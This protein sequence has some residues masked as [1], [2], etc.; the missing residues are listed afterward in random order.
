MSNPSEKRYNG[1]LI[2]TPVVKDA[3]SKARASDSLF[4][5][6]HV[7]PNRARVDRPP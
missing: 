7:K 6:Q 2:D 4:G 3:Q 5:W 1:L